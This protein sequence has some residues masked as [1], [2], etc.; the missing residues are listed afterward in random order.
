[1]NIRFTIEETNLISIFICEDRASLI[2]EISDVLPYMDEDVLNLVNRALEK[3]RAMIDEEFAGLDIYT[4]DEKNAT[5]ARVR[6]TRISCSRQ[7]R[8]TA[9]TSVQK[10]NISVPKTDRWGA[11]PI[12]LPRPVI[13][14]FEF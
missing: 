13:F 14:M 7:E 4:A 5:C 6:S 2:E 12:R 8:H 11:A 1:M 3:F 10:T 9:Q